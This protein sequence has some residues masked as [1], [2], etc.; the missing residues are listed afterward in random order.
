MK[1]GAE[2]VNYQPI[3]MLRTRVMTILI[4]LVYY[5]ICFAK[6]IDIFF[7][8]IPVGWEL[9]ARSY[10]LGLVISPSTLTNEKSPYGAGRE[11]DWSSS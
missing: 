1:N 4:L 3:F 10:R 8:K 9:D 2:R 6:N 5:R 7:F 11:P